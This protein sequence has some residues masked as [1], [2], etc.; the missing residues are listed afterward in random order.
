MARSPIE[1]GF[2]YATIVRFRGL[3][4]ARPGPKYSANHKLP[5]GVEVMSCGRAIGVGV[6]NSVTTPVIVIRPMRLA[7]RSVNHMLP[8]APVVMSATLPFGSFE[9]VGTSN[10]SIAPEVTLI[11]ATLLPYNSVS[12]IFPSGPDV[13]RMGPLLGVG[14]V[15]AL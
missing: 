7:A 8:S 9:W 11:L 15:Y 3:I 4:L 6:V 5:S 2:E 10:S 12:Q 13:G 14:M 1:V